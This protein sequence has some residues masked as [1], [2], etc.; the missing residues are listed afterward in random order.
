MYADGGGLYLQVGD[1]GRAKSWLFRYQV[2]NGKERQMGLGPLH[3]IGLAE[4]RE[5]ARLARVQRLN[6]VDPIEARKTA[7]EQ[8]KLDAAKNVTF[9]H[10]AE[11]WMEAHQL[12]RSARYQRQL[13]ATFENHIYPKIG[14]SPVQMISVNVL[15]EML[16]P[17]HEKYPPTYSVVQMCIEGALRW[18]IAKGYI[19]PPNPAS[20]EGPL[21]ELLLPVADIH[22]VK[23]H[24]SLPWRRVG[25]FM[26]ELRA[27]RANAGLMAHHLRRCKLC[28]DPQLA[29]EVEAARREGVT[30]REILTRFDV[31]WLCINQHERWKQ[32]KGQ[33]NVGPRSMAS[34]ALEFL[35]LT[36]VRR[37]Q[38]A[39]ARWEDIDEI[40][41]VWDCPPEGH[42]SGPKTGKYHI[43]PLSK[44]AVALLKEL[45]ANG[46]KGE[47]VFAAKSKKT[48]QM[49]HIHPQSINIFQNRQLRRTVTERAKA[50]GQKEHKLSEQL[51]DCVPHGFRTSFKGWAIEKGHPEEDSEMQLAHT[52]GSSVRNVYARFAERIEPRR[53]M[54]NEWADE[55]ARTEPLPAGVSDLTE[56]LARK[57]LKRRSAK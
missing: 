11:D 7:R 34:Y 54:M 12:K 16:K 56:R 22:S 14:K 40:D 24:E 49:S 52:V 5:L 26:R 32:A 36:G 44:A 20:L 25:E 33:E 37:E 15:H 51:F 42:K 17:I 19:S 41:W 2:E 38:A 21:G 13:V 6:G 55:C 47:F 3:T 46:R 9:R 50:L 35:I 4:A 1:G 53:I 30:F 31:N 27:H 45:Q 57:R 48:G 8:Q 39:K 43:V 29:A 28:K 10:C 23:P 18:A